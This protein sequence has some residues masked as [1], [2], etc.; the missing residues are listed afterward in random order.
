MAVHKVDLALRHFPR[1]VGLRDGALS[2]DVP[3]SEVQSDLLGTLYSR[4]GKSTA[5]R[6][7]DYFQY[8]LG[9]AR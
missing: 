1:V 4:D 2:F 5:E 6:D 7:G 3:P 8:K 9:C